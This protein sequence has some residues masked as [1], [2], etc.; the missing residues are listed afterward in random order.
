MWKAF[1]G[2]EDQSRQFLF[3]I[4]DWGRHYQIYLLSP[5][6]PI[7]PRWGKW[8]TKKIGSSILGYDRYRFQL[9]ANPTTKRIVHHESGERK[10]NGR[11]TAIYD[12]DE[13]RGWLERKAK[14]AGFHVEGFDYDPPI[15]QP[16]RKKGKAGLHSRVDFR[17]VLKVFDSSA[18]KVA[19]SNGIGP[20][21]A[22]GF[23]MLVLEPIK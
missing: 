3:R 20:A 7:T 22:F 23:G 9:R 11:R 21:K 17:G 10:K 4:D 13:L 16:F 19:F 1:P 15:S 6:Q 12:R 14:S 8:E 5:E 2:K 18:F